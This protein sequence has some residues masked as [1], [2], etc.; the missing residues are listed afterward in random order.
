MIS[1][2]KPPHSKT[3]SLS[4]CCRLKACASTRRQTWCTSFSHKRFHSSNTCTSQESLWVLKTNAPLPRKSY[5]HYHS[6]SETL[7]L[8]HF[9]CF[10]LGTLHAP[11]LLCTRF[12]CLLRTRICVQRTSCWTHLT[13]TS[14]L[15][16]TTSSRSRSSLSCLQSTKTWALGQLARF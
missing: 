16:T 14:M 8:W 7:T 13:C 9:C 4:I 5:Y 3:S 11:W 1:S 2:E 15:L 12:T 10:L 6:C